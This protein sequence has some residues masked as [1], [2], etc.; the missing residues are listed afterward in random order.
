M[1]TFEQKIYNLT[2]FPVECFTKH[3][4]IFL[5]TLLKGAVL[6]GTIVGTRGVSFHVTFHLKCQMQHK[7]IMIVNNINKTGL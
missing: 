2:C 5:L 3:I 1:G 4:I 7:F 6:E